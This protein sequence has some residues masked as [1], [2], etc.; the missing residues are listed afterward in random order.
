M[1]KMLRTV[2]GRAIAA[3]LLV[4]ALLILM[5]I[6]APMARASDGPITLTADYTLTSDMTF[7]GTGFIIAADDITFDLGGH[8]ITGGFPPVPVL[9]CGVDASG[10]SGVT[11]KNGTING[12][13]F[14]V[15]LNGSDNNII[16]NVVVTNS[17]GNGI[18][19]WNDS[20]GNQIEGCTVTNSGLGGGNYVG[21]YIYNSSDNNKVKDTICSNNSRYGIQVT[22]SAGNC[23][24]GNTTNG[25]SLYGVLL[26]VGADDNI[27]KDSISSNN[28]QN[29]IHISDS[30]GNSVEGNTV[31]GNSQYGVFL[32]N[33]ANSNTVQGN[34]VNNNMVAGILVYLG[35]DTNIV[36]D[37]I[38]CYNGGGIGVWAQ[39]NTVQGN[40][41]RNNAG[42]G[43]G[44]RANNNQVLSNTV[45]SNGGIGVFVS[46]AGA[47]N[48]TVY[49]NN[50]ISNTTQ[51]SVSGGS[52]NLFNL[53]KPTG[54]NYWSDW[55]SPDA[56]YDGFVDSPYVFTGG[57]DNFPWA[58][59]NGWLDKTP[60]TIT[61]SAPVDGS[62]YLLN[63]VVNASWS[64]TDT[65]SGVNPATVVAT[66]ANGLPIDTGTVGS[67]S[68][69]VSARDYAGNAATR[70]VTYS[71]IG[72]SGFLPPVEQNRVFKLGSTIPVKFQLT[73]ASGNFITDATAT[74]SLQKR[75]DSVWGSPEE[76]E[77]TSA[78]TSGNLF[79][80][81]PVSNQYIFNLATKPLSAG[82]WRITITVY[83][84]GFA[85]VDIGLK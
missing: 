47:N 68:F 20:D 64:V 27:V 31:T 75:T 50:F 1:K 63:Q 82:T 4:L 59:Q 7:S 37:N 36:Q 69:T 70:T 22:G 32:Y 12:F 6:P 77:S 18:S 74:I 40:V 43:I 72:F 13:G 9:E 83:G 14:G 39:N 85:S 10:H 44:L 2:G 49:N 67:H 25:N 66:K 52:G 21:I 33:G 51:A 29:G 80:Y 41:V 16:K 8:T 17:K 57:Q 3:S 62:V 46:G 38:V 54:G 45:S 79:R 11:I 53:G 58:V 34:T 15:V 30:D 60:P 35:A 55:N 84:T 28:G 78:A 26:Y 76:G 61:I 81:D 42:N 65:E 24:E 73:D 48:N 19:L 56:D 71:V 5:V 23:L